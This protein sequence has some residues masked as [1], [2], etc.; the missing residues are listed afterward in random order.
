MLNEV[1]NLLNSTQKRHW[2]DIIYSDFEAIALESRP[3]HIHH[4]ARVLKKLYWSKKVIYFL[5]LH[6]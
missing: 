2:Y 6:M 3:L 1:L 4:S 5:R